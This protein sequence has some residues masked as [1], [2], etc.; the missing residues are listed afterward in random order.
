MSG[1]ERLDTHEYNPAKHSDLIAF[2]DKPR[3]RTEDHRSF[4]ARTPEFRIPANNL[5]EDESNHQGNH[6]R[7]FYLV[8]GPFHIYLSNISFKLCLGRDYCVI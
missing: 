5:S 8:E 3:K 4:E 7:V 6:N 1:W 2:E